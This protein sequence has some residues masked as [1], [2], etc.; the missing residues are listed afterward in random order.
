MDGQL[1]PLARQVLTRFGYR[2]LEAANATE[3]MAV[4]QAFDGSIEL[5]LTD[6]VMPGE[7]GLKLSQR[8]LNERPSIRVL[9]MS[10]YADESVTRMGQM[11]PGTTLLQK[12]F[13]PNDL[14]RAIRSALA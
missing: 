4:A 3:A 11:Q 2:V 1:R 10:G 6:M 14:A 13:V 12:P 7:N 5:L 8:I 9:Y